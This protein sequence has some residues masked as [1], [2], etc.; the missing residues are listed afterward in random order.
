M[1]EELQCPI[2]SCRNIPLIRLN[3]DS[4]TISVFCNEHQN[5]KSQYELGYS[6]YIANLPEPITPEYIYGYPKLERDKKLYLSKPRKDNSINT[7]SARI[8]KE[9]GYENNL[10]EYNNFEREK[11]FDFFNSKYGNDAHKK[12]TKQ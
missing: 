5:I 3:N 9:K 6:M 10:T 2:S 8:N 4:S 11:D 7:R 1:N 12:K